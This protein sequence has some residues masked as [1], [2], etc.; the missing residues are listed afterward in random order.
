MIYSTSLPIPLAPKPRPPTHFSNFAWAGTAPETNW[1]AADGQK[2]TKGS[3]I[4]IMRPKLASPVVRSCILNSHTTCVPL[5]RNKT[6]APTSHPMNAPM[7][8]KL[9]MLYHNRTR[10]LCAMDAVVNVKTSNTE[11]RLM[12]NSKRWWSGG[13]SEFQV[14]YIILM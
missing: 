8:L 10:L 12:Q 7:P 3:Y 4:Y 13:G 2:G 9:S 14:N 5:Y 11:K 6:A 1:E